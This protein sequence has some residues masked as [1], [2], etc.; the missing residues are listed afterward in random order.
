MLYEV[1]QYKIFFCYINKG[2]GKR[3]IITYN[4]LPILSDEYVVLYEN[5]ILK[6]FLIYKSLSPILLFYPI[7][8]SSIHSMPADNGSQT[9]RI[10]FTDF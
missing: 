4:T 8:Y 2:Y 5:S 10:G 3:L 9:N 7:I 6:F 1:K